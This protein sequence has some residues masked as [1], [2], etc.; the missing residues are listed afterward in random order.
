MSGGSISISSSSSGD[1]SSSTTIARF[2]IASRKR[3]GNRARALQRRRRSNAA[4]VIGFAA[5]RFGSASRLA[6]RRAPRWRR[7]RAGSSRSRP[8]PR[9]GRR[10]ASAGRCGGRA[11]SA[12]P[13]RASSAPGGSAPHSCC[14]TIIGIVRLRRCRCGWRRAARGDRPAGPGT[15]SAW[16]S[17]TFAVLRPTPGSSTSASMSAGTSPPWSLDER[18]RHADE[19]LRLRAEEAGRV[20]LR[21]ELRRC[22]ARASA[23]ASG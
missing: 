12:R 11:G 23:R 5:A 16:P 7:R 18:L 13:R 10:A 22:V 6:V 2:C 20:N 15:P 9:I 3:R 17:T 4:R 8:A 19:R 1:G 21:L 14:S